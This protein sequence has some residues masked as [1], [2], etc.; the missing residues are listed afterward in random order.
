MNAPARQEQLHPEQKAEHVEGE[1]KKGRKVESPE[2]AAEIIRAGVEA[3]RHSAEKVVISRMEAARNLEPENPDA[4]ENLLRSEPTASELAESARQLEAA[5]QAIET[6]ASSLEA[7]LTTNEIPTGLEA[8]TEVVIQESPSSAIEPIEVSSGPN[9]DGITSPDQIASLHELPTE[10]RERTPLANEILTE[11]IH[12]EHGGPK[13]SLDTGDGLASNAAEAAFFAD[14]DAQAAEREQLAR[15][16]EEKR[17]QDIDKRAAATVE[18]ERKAKEKRTR[19]IDKAIDKRVRK[20]A[21]REAAAAKAEEAKTKERVE[22]HDDLVEQETGE[23][24]V[25]DIALLKKLH[26]VVTFHEKSGTDW[27]LKAG[28]VR[29]R[30]DALVT[31]LAKKNPQFAEHAEA[32]NISQFIRALEANKP[33][34]REGKIPQSEF[35]GR[36]IE[37]AIAQ[38]PEDER[39]KTADATL[40]EYGKETITTKDADGKEQSREVVTYG[41]IDSKGDTVAILNATQ[42][43]NA[44]NALL[45]K[46]SLGNRFQADIAHMYM[47][48]DATERSELQSQE[49]KYDSD[50]VKKLQELYLQLIGDKSASNITP[51]KYIKAAKLEIKILRKAGEDTTEAEQDLTAWQEAKGKI[52]TYKKLSAERIELMQQLEAARSAAFEG[53][54]AEFITSQISKL[55]EQLKD[56]D[57]QFQEVVSDLRVNPDVFPILSEHHGA[58]SAYES[59]IQSREKQRASIQ[60]LRG[61][62]ERN[63]AIMQSILAVEGT[64]KLTEDGKL[65][66]Q[67]AEGGKPLSISLEP[68]KVQELLEHERSVMKLQTEKLFDTRQAIREQLNNASVIP[69]E[70]RGDIYQGYFDF[71]VKDDMSMTIS[72]VDGNNIGTHFEIPPKLARGVLDGT[73]P[74]GDSIT[75]PDAFTTGADSAHENVATAIHG[76]QAQGREGMNR[77]RQ[78][79]DD[80]RIDKDAPIDEQQE[81]YVKKMELEKD[82]HKADYENTQIALDVLDDIEGDYDLKEHAAIMNQIGTTRDIYLEMQNSSTAM[83]DIHNHARGVA[84]RYSGDDPNELESNINQALR[85][86]VNQRAALEQQ[87][88]QSLA[89]LNELIATDKAQ[90]EA[91]DDLIDTTVAPFSTPDSSPTASKDTEPK[92]K[93]LRNASAQM[94]NRLESL[95]TTPDGAHLQGSLIED[96]NKNRGRNIGM[97]ADSSG[98]LYIGIVGA[99]GRNLTTR[100]EPRIDQGSPIW[101]RLRSMPEM[102]VLQNT[103]NQ[104]AKIIP[105]PDAAAEQPTTVVTPEAAATTPQIESDEGTNRESTMN[106]IQDLVRGFGSVIDSGERD[107]LVALIGQLDT[108]DRLGVII[109]AI[110][111]SSLSSNID[112]AM[113]VIGD[114]LTEGSSRDQ[115]INEVME[116]V[117]NDS[118]ADATAKMIAMT[119]DPQAR[120]AA[121]QKLQALENA[122]NENEAATQVE[123]MEPAAAEVD[124]PAESTPEPE[125]ASLVSEMVIERVSAAGQALQEA[126]AALQTVELSDALQQRFNALSDRQDGLDGLSMTIVDLRERAQSELDSGSGISTETTSGIAAAIESTKQLQ[127]DLTAFANETEVINIEAS[128]NATIANWSAELTNLSQALEAIPIKTVQAAA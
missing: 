113:K 82:Y 114:S 24:E 111:D 122:T 67:S 13:V 94:I 11:P 43:E 107:K 6:L 55:A 100:F 40:F 104:I 62:I 56:N 37:H 32:G 89:K 44:R 8:A 61:G 26:S 96:I 17:W 91:G 77:M 83:I 128:T 42:S 57:E 80:I 102:S 21:K 22:R 39:E 50:S 76:E 64:F 45:M 30:R 66:Y 109:D 92:S 33:R 112:D 51:E 101:Q 95:A 85:A 93:E 75:A 53:E 2:Q 18:A 119:G 48:R 28:R 121:E 78:E 127:A 117:F 12:T 103:E 4:A 23:S 60:R 25:K 54:E 52:T 87:V 106:D 120:R 16:Q 35:H 58:L 125:S 27:Y 46:E 59:E 47:E 70:Y 14:G 98:N 10:A 115:V 41:L 68:E 88:S 9:V 90:Q 20:G 15:Q 5:Q 74:R 49:T 105:Q 79:I 71:E 116:V 63:Q 7:P 73:L 118:G 29:N 86:V 84:E 69:K 3:V 110:Q 124:A 123:T 34:K 38:L 81:E 31:E 1:G 65:E 36:L 19:G 108:N 97:R 72:I 126:Q 99:D